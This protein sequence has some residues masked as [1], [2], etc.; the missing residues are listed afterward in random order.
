MNAELN[1]LYFFFLLFVLTFQLDVG[2]TWY[3]G[4][5]DWNRLTRFQ[6]FRHFI[7]VYFIIINALSSK[8]F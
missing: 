1:P 3:L 6:S 2:S 8:A 7:R 4:F 5:N